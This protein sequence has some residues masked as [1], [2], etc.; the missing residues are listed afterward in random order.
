MSSV[1]FVVRAAMIVILGLMPQV[2]GAQT[3]APVVPAPAITESDT[4]KPEW[5]CSDPASQD[6]SLELL[7]ADRAFA[8]TL[9]A[10]GPLAAYQDVISPEGILHD[11]SG[12]SPE[13]PAG[14]QARFASFPADVSFEREPESALAS[15][16]SGSSWGRYVI[17][18]GDKPLSLGRYIS[19]WRREAGTWRLF[20]ELAAGRA[21]QQA[22]TA[23]GPLPR[24]PPTAGQSPDQSATPA[25]SK[26]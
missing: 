25:S 21:G 15:G 20:T 19:V 17:K 11:A 10:Q 8:A 2:V 12:A 18:K 24:R 14:A 5:R 1:H 3:S 23:V 9:A 16:G 6:E 22:A 4:A 7:A 13:G 26:P